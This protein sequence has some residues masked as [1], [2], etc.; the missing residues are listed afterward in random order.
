MA[1]VELMQQRPLGLAQVEIQRGLVGQ[2]QFMAKHRLKP[3]LCK[4]TLP[5]GSGTNDR[6]SS[7]QGPRSR[8]TGRVPIRSRRLC[9]PAVDPVVAGSA[10][11]TSSHRRS[12]AAES[13][14]RPDWPARPPTDRPARASARP[15]RKRCGI[16]TCSSCS[17]A[18]SGFIPAGLL[19]LGGGRRKRA[20]R[21]ARTR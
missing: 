18:E 21:S 5:G 7:V 19:L 3:L 20:P 8:R 10:A 2:L 12:P 6:R 14:R 13:A 16:A 4:L 17:G 1:L 11:V 15:D 9:G